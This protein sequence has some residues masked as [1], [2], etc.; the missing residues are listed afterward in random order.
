M[1]SL[2]TRHKDFIADNCFSLILFD[3][4]GKSNIKIHPFCLVTMLTL[5]ATSFTLLR[6]GFSGLL[7]EGLG[8]YSSPKENLRN[9]FS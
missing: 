8:S 6:M 3:I 9:V 1:F 4:F 5:M 2:Y 7:M